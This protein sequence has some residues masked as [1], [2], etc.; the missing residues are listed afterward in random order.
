MGAD[1]PGLHSLAAVIMI[2]QAQRDFTNLDISWGCPDEG[3]H[4]G[5]GEARRRGVDECR[6]GEWDRQ[7]IP[8]FLLHDY[9][10]DNDVGIDFEDD[11]HTLISDSKLGQ[12]YWAQAAAYSIYTR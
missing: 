9:Y 11:V 5:P 2:R 1:I 6:G 4:Q 12:S 8:E 7:G 10:K 3:L